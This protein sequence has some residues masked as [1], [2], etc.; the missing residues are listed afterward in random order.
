M[1]NL[2]AYLSS[3]PPPRNA[4]L[5][6]Y[7]SASP[8]PP[9]LAP[10]PAGV[11]QQPY[12]APG[13]LQL[14]LPR[15]SPPL[16]PPNAEATLTASQASVEADASDLEIIKSRESKAS[17]NKTRIYRKKSLPATTSL[18]LSSGDSSYVDA[19]PV[20]DC[21]VLLTFHASSSGP[22]LTICPAPPG[23]RMKPSSVM[24]GNSAL[25]T[26]ADAE[27]YLQDS[28]VRTAGLGMGADSKTTAMTRLLGGPD[29]DEE[30]MLSKTGRRKGG[31]VG[32]G[33]AGAAVPPSAADDGI[34]GRGGQARAAVKDLVS[35]SVYAGDVM[36]GTMGVT[37]G[38]QMVLG[39]SNDDEFGGGAEFRPGKV[40]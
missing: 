36:Q 5:P 3:L 35:N 20:P 11:A 37:G 14:I 9:S 4:S 7:L 25:R 30:T 19:G 16:I 33:K 24:G 27:R 17:F 2:D 38:G 32:S 21:Y 10:P 12:V 39:G 26:V 6:V 28:M 1:A 18:S 15:P 13:A 8:P 34:F 29:V 23:L 22:R 31:A 40:G